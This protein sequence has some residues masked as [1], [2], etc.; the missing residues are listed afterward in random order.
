[1]DFVSNSASLVQQ[2]FHL[3]RHISSSQNF[4]DTAGALSALIAV[5]YFRFESWVQASGLVTKDPASG[6]PVV[7]DNSLRRC[8]LLAAD[9]NWATLDYRTVEE[10]I[11]GILSE[12]YRCLEKLNKLRGKY[13]MHLTSGLS[14]SSIPPGQVS[15]GT[16]PS[17]ASTPAPTGLHNV[18]PLF[19]SPR[20]AATLSRDTTIRQERSR[21]VSFFRKVNFA[22]SLSNDV[23]DR[24]KLEEALKT[25]RDL[26]D[27]LELI[28]PSSSRSGNGAEVTGRLVSLKMLSVTAEPTELRSIGEAM[29]T[30]AGHVDLYQAIHTAAIVKAKR[31]EGGVSPSELKRVVLEINMLVGPQA[32]SQGK[33]TRTLCK[34]R[35]DGSIVLVE[36]TQYPDSLPDADIQLLNERIATLALLLKLAGHPYF[37]PLP[38][39]HGYIRYTRTQFGLVYSLPDS[40][41]PSREPIPLYS[42]L[43]TTS[44]RNLETFGMTK[45]ISRNTLPALEE[46]YRLAHALADGVLSLLSVSWV[47]K[48]LCSWNILLFRSRTS[49]GAIDFS[50]PL[51]AGFGVS[52]REKPGEITIDTRDPDCPLRLWQHPDLRGSTHVRFQP[53]YDLYSLGLMLFEIAM[54]QDLPSFDGH[55]DLQTYVL[56]HS[57][58][59]AHRMGTTYRDAMMACLDDDF[60]WDEASVPGGETMPL[61]FADDVVAKLLLCVEGSKC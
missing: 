27:H 32:P 2:V 61:V 41:D 48:S 58:V 19:S 45:R 53:K 37:K 44:R 6:E 40:A 17:P 22:W 54:W 46:R 16:A 29:V 42:L 4:S 43:P 5:E 23:S 3:Y 55:E 24:V 25:L 59:V 30:R 8:I 15:Q 21:A 50:R 56:N 11:L 51:I 39:C 36:G 33:Q 60:R 52:R 28:L 38:G 20:V 13:A 57:G 12:V 26:N 9:A 1:M 47:H 7:H 10:T 31:L 18:D 49:Q 35:S 34:F 14:S